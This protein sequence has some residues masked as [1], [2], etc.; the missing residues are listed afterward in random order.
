MFIDTFI[1]EIIKLVE[2][3]SISKKLKIAKENKTSYKILNHYTKD[4]V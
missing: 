2:E 1:T 3:K 4:I